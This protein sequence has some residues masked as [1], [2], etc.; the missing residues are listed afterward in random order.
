MGTGRL[1][2]GRGPGHAVRAA[3]AIAAIA[4]HAETD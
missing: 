1:E 4:D 2:L 3:E